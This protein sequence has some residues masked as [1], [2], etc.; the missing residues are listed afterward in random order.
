VLLATPLTIVVLVLIRRLYLEED[1][2]EVLE[3]GDA[4]NPPPPPISTEGEALV[5]P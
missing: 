2:H 4:P 1:K 5:L 3:S